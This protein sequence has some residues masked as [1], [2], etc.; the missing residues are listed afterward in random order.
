M[1]ER[2]VTDSLYVYGARYISIT[3]VHHISLRE[4]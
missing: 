2:N 4:I 3:A 1:G